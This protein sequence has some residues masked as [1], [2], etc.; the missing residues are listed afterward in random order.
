MSRNGQTLMPNIC[1]G[2]AAAD[3]VDLVGGYT[4]E[5]LG[6]PVRRERERP[7]VMGIIVAPHQAFEA[8]E[9]AVADRQRV[10]HERRVGLPLQ[11]V[12]RMHVDLGGPHDV[13]DAEVV[14]PALTE[15]VVVE[16]HGEGE[17]AR[18]P[19]GAD[20]VQVG[21]ALEDA[22]VRHPAQRLAHAA[23]LHVPADVLAAGVGHQTGT[24]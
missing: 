1:R 20:H 7:L 4:V 6:D 8:G 22:A 15:V 14:Q 13:V 11:V 23:A 9:I 18:V 12:A 21:V 3:L 17:P 2:V 5:L 24:H 10:P 16:L 19:L